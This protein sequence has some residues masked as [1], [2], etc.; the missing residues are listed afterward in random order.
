[1][2]RP[3]ACSR[4]DLLKLV[5]SEKNT[6]I[7]G[8]QSIEEA[9]FVSDQITILLPRPGRGHKIIRP[10]Q[11]EGGADPVTV[12]VRA[13]ESAV[14]LRPQ[15][16]VIVTLKAHCTSILRDRDAGRP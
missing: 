6:L 13:S 15:D 11:I 12:L 7:F 3:G 4:E 9:V 5:K 1:M 16:W 2:N 10:P 14:D 8:T